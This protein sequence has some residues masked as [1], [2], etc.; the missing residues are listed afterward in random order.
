VLN[1]KQL[2]LRVRL[3][4]HAG[5]HVRYDCRPVSILLKREGWE[6]NAKGIYQLYNEEA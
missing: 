4:G 6:V 3:C 5:S 2:H 1:E